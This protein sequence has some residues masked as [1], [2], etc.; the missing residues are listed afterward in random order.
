[1]LV[2]GT[3]AGGATADEVDE[4]NAAFLATYPETCTGAFLEDGSPA[5]DPDVFTL[6]YRVSW[7]E[8]SEP[9]REL[10]LYQ[11]KCTIGAYNV[12]NAFF[13]VTEDEGIKPLQLAQPTFRVAYEGSDSVDDPSYEKVVESITL[14]GITTY[15]TIANAEVD[16]STG[17]IRSTGYWRGIGDASSA[18]EWRLVEGDFIL[19]RYD[20]DASYDGEV[21]P[22]T[23]WDTVAAIEAG[24]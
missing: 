11:Y 14:T 2:F 10:T 3:L 17:K 8:E 23:V 19:V 20:I 9:D 1:V 22:Q 7:Q 24:R 6:K 12:G 13:V 15:P 16:A 4:V 18:G 21:N 5:Y